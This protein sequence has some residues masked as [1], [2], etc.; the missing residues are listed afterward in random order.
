[1]TALDIS[2]EFVSLIS[3]AAILSLAYL[4]VCQRG[5]KDS[6]LVAGVKRRR[7]LIAQL[8]EIV[9]NEDDAARLLRVEAARLKDTPS[10]ERVLVSAITRARQGPDYWQNLWEDV[11]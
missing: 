3:L 2:S 10:S 4:Y 9:D 1:M 6:Q 8:K 11:V 7:Q 5:P